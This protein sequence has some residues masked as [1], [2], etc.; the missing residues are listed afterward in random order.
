[1]ASRRLRFTIEARLEGWVA[2][3]KAGNRPRAV[4]AWGHMSIVY[5]TLGFRS[6]AGRV[7]VFCCMWVQHK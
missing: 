2:G 6:A 3:Q 7:K 1:M 4:T 5:S